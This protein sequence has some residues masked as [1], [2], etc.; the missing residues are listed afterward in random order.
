VKA[1]STIAVV[2]S[3]LVFSGCSDKQADRLLGT[4][5]SQL[6]PSEWGSNRI[7]MTFFAD[8]RTAGTNAFLEGTEL[9]WHGSY[10]VQ[11]SLIHRTIEGRIQEIRFRIDGDSMHMTIGSED[12]TFTQVITEP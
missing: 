4:W 6:I 5:Q 10:R 2:I 1:I 9:A 12:Y 7:T 11:G 3:V 8:G